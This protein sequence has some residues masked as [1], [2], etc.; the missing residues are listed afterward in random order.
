MAARLSSTTAPLAKQWT[1]S[2]KQLCTKKGP[3]WK[4]W[5]T[6]KSIQTANGATGE[7]KA[8]WSKLSNNNFDKQLPG[9]VYTLGAMVLA[10]LDDGLD[11]HVY[12]DRQIHDDLLKTGFPD[13]I[14]LTSRIEERYQADNIDVDTLVSKH[15]KDFT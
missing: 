14:H 2:T 7:T 9:G 8:D 3:D 11:I 5:A 15:S 4:H 10:L 12:H 6:Y 1:Y 13:L